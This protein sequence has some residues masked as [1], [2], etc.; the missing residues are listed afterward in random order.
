MK[1][2]LTTL[3]SLRNRSLQIASADV[4]VVR[5]TYSRLT[6]VFIVS[7]CTLGGVALTQYFTTK[8]N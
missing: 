5:P 2:L 3:W 7:A 6:S 4:G 8:K 1:K